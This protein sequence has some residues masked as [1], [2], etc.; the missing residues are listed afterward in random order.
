M[1]LTEHHLL[2]MACLLKIRLKNLKVTFLILRIGN[3]MKLTM[4]LFVQII[5][6]WVLIDML[7]DMTNMDSN[8]T[9]NYMNVMIVQVI[10]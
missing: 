2:P 1:I 4:N 9:L 3:T 8:E 7:T 10:H 6:D 5:N